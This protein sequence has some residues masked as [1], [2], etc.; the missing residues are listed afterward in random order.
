MKFAIAYSLPIRSR[1]NLAQTWYWAGVI[2]AFLHASESW[3][4]HRNHIKPC[5]GY[6]QWCVY[7]SLQSTDNLSQC[8]LLSQHP[9]HWGSICTWLYIGHVVLLVSLTP[10]SRNR[11]LF[12][13]FILLVDSGI[14]SRENLREKIQ[15]TV[16]SRLLKVKVYSENLSS[17]H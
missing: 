14:D 6:E 5:E 2:S 9:E 17:K 15:L 11:L 3:P 4:I 8:P 13:N 12:H 10:N 7:K 16:G 1:S